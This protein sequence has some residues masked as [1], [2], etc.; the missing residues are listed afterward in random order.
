MK[1]KLLI[2]T[3]VLLCIFSQAQTLDDQLDKISDE[4]T[5]DLKSKKAYVIAVYPFSSLKK[6]E[7]NLSLHIFG[8]LHTSLK[9]KERDFKIM[10][11]LTLDNYLAEHELN[12]ND[13]IDK[14]TAK[15]FGKLIAADAYVTGKV[16]QFGSVINL[17]VKLT[18]TETGEI[19]SF[20]SVK[21]PIDYDMAEFLEIKDWD[22]KRKKANV[23]KSQNPSCNFLSIGNYC[24][25]NNAGVPVK[26]VLTAKGG[27]SRS[28]KELVIPEGNNGCFKD[29][30]VNPYTFTVYRTDRVGIA[31][32]SNVIAQGN[33]SVEKCSSQIQK[34][35]KTP[36]KGVSQG[37]IVSANQKLF[38]ITISNPNYFSREVTF[39]NRN[40]ESESIIIGS[41][42]TGT[43]ELPEG[44]YRFVSHTTFTKYKV[45][46]SS[47]KLRSNKTITLAKDDYN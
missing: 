35:T 41:K 30:A 2:L 42:S 15:Q 8:E 31:G 12:S 34:V 22:T 18:D 24:F 14:K 45:Q 44:F 7:S 28:R 5:Q 32:Q 26:I 43:V 21:M 23:N 17:T 25:N 37:N 6:K 29:L 9:A 11:R 46:Q 33:F 1:K 3:S 4:I 39:Y 40:N 10:D 16:Y 38:T 36:I 27:I 20:N 19:V 47:L 13:L